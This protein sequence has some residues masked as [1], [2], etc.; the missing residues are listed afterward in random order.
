MW[1]PKTE[2]EKTRVRQYRREH[3]KKWY[4]AHREV[5][6]E[7]QSNRRKANRE[8]SNAYWRVQDAV[9]RGTLRPKPCE[10]CDATENIYAH[11]WSYETLEDIYDV[12]WLCL[13]HHKEAHKLMKEL[14]THPLP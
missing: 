10:I 1:K 9:Q 5:V 7:R 4:A 2:E 12:I 3:Q 6:C 14:S 11:H 13:V 8:K